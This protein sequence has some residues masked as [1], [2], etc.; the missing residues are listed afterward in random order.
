MKEYSLYSLL[1]QIVSKQ[2]LKML[3]SGP[4]ATELHVFLLS[5]SVSH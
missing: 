5:F 2:D 3:K 4:K 1:L